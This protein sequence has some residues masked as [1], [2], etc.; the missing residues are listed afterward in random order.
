[1]PTLLVNHVCPFTESVSLLRRAIV[2]AEQVLAPRMRN[3]G[4]L[5]DEVVADAGRVGQ[6]Q[7]VQ[8]RQ[9]ARVGAIRRDDVAGERLA[10]QRIA[11]RRSA[12]RPACASARSRRARSSAV[13]IM[14][15]AGCC[16]FF[17]RVSSSE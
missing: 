16:G 13:G 12:R 9:A 10:G 3:A 14:K 15:R 11:N 2:H 4:F 8:K 1:M 6:R 5:I 7:H 17:S